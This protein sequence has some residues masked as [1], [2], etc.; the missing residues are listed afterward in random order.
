MADANPSRPVLSTGNASS[1][2]IE[3]SVPTDTSVGRRKDGRVVRRTTFADGKIRDDF[4]NEA[5]FSDAPYFDAPK[6]AKPD[7]RPVSKGR[8]K[9]ES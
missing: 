8:A 5:E 2:R 4:V 9:K 6:V 7:P 3:R 1:S